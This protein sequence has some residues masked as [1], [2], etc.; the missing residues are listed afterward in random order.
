M[1]LYWKCQLAGWTLLWGYSTFL[2]FFT[3]TPIKN[4][5]PVI[6][7]CMIIGI[8]LSHLM[9]KIIEWLK[10]LQRNLFYQILWILI[11][12]VL[13]SI[14]NMF[15]IRF[16]IYASNSRS[17]MY[18]LINANKSYLLHLFQSFTLDS[19]TFLTWNLFYFTYKY[20]QRAKIEER[21]KFNRE[22]ELLEIE[23]KAL[24][25]Q[26]NPHFIFNCM[27]SIKSLIQ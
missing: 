19:F 16:L 8:L 13:F 15:I 9:K 14:L 4:I 20:V 1:S 7:Y 17:L 3:N 12:T 21:L 5:I 6:L 10:I 23:A 18:D 11:S 26:M 27:N 25:A 2:N 24:R 22:K